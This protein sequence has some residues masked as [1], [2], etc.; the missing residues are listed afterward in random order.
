M[1]SDMDR[2]DFEGRLLTSQMLFHDDDASRFVGNFWLDL[3]TRCW[4]EA[5][6]SI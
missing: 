1:V 3:S 2:C 4:V 6:W 5:Y